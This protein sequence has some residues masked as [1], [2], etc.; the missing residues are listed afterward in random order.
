M[1]MQLFRMRA[2][3]ASKLCGF[4]NL[5]QMSFTHDEFEPLYPLLKSKKL[6]GFLATYATMRRAWAVNTGIDVSSGLGYVQWIIMAIGLIFTLIMGIS[7]GFAFKNDAANAK[8]QLIG[9]ILIP[10]LFA[11][12]LYIFNKTL[13]ISLNAPS[14]L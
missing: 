10:V 12:V 5:L 13:G 2:I 8:A 1:K 4:V 7:T 6:A 9:T 3:L 14:G 11:I